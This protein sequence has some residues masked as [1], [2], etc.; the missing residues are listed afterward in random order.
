MTEI[1]LPI[2]RISALDP[3]FKQQLNSCLK[4]EMLASDEIFQQV[5]EILQDV[6]VNGNRAVIDYTNKF[7]NFEV[8]S[9]ESLFVSQKQL[10][11]SLDRISVPQRQAL[12]HAANRIQ[13]YHERQLTSSWEYE[14][15]DG[16][17]YGQKITP[18]ERVGLYVPGGKAN[19]PSSMLMLAIPAKVAG[20][21]D[22][23]AVVPSR[24]S[25]KNDLIFAA[26]KIAGVSEVF[27]M[28]GA[29]AIAAL[30]YGTET[31]PR[32]DKIAGPGNVYVNVAKRIV[33]GDVGIDM[34]AGPSE[35]T[36]IC[37]GT[38]D[39]DWIAA[40]LFS[41][42]EHDEF[43][44]SILI[45][46]SSEYLNRV[47]AS[48]NFLLPKMDRREIIQTSLKNRGIFIHVDS[49]Q[50]AAEVSNLIAPEH[51][52]ISISKPKSILPNITNAGAIFIGRYS[53]EALGD[54][55][56]GPSHVL[57]TSGTSRFFSALGVYD[58][59]KR[60]SIIS[61]SSSGAASLAET[62]AELARNE[63]LQAHALSAEYRKNKSAD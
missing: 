46:N 58:F 49:V 56:A 59:Q 17:V 26:A 61:C 63:L 38:T 44:Q 43:A 9:F 42:A 12:E 34:V 33:F 10:V 24:Y 19:Y 5:K 11:K 52:E 18:L 54:Y 45:A 7:D 2:A 36:I 27:T 50:Q 22:I 4:R 40:D 35:L 3:D 21:Q 47:E 37:D 13:K 41:Q 55:C 39:P 8:D 25:E 6:R 60:S 48:I 29:Q 28:G 23:I 62:A 57:P 31:L 16:S 51:L 30:A 1:N 53:A 20:V 14:E 15:E 32:V